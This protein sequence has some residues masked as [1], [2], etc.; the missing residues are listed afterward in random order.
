MPRATLLPVEISPPGVATALPGGATLQPGRTARPLRIAA[1]LPGATPP[2]EATPLPRGAPLP[3]SAPPLRITQL[4]GELPGELPMP[5]GTKPPPGRAAGS[6]RGD[7][8]RTLQRKMKLLRK[9][10]LVLLPA[11]M[12]ATDPQLTGSHLPPGRSA[13]SAL[14]VT[15]R[16][17][18]GSPGSQVY[19]TDEWPPPSHRA[20]EG[21]PKELSLPPPV[22]SARG[23]SS[24]TGKAGEIEG[25]KP[26]RHRR[27][28]TEDCAKPWPAT[29]CL[30][31]E[32]IRRSR[33]HMRGRGGGAQPL[34]GAARGDSLLAAG[35]W[36][37]LAP[38]PWEPPMHLG[39]AEPTSGLGR[40]AE[41]S[42]GVTKP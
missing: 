7:T 13:L 30:E 19:T 25:T 36:F 18:R 40:L 31:R 9:S 34:A 41:R 8:E 26:L 29:T 2:P 39:S 32:K 5:G 12:R 10:M 28:Q 17:D 11:L 14:G 20:K 37:L 42:R 22:G 35:R 1:Q 6:A 16:R 23:S 38:L 33:N 4:L 15:V 3:G 24:E 27:P 21:R